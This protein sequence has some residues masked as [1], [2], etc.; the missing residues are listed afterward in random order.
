MTTSSAVPLTDFLIKARA[1]SRNLVVCDEHALF[2]LCVLPYLE[3]HFK[4]QRF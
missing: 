4:I 3:N 1:S 2:S